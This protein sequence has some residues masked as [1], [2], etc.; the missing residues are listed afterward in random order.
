MVDYKSK[1]SLYQTHT[2]KNISL[3]KINNIICVLSSFMIYFFC[4][5]SFRK[6]FHYASHERPCKVLN[7]LKKWS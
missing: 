4:I 6:F 7:F 5:M 2:E 1:T 3:R